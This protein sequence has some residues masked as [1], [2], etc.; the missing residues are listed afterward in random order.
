[1]SEKEYIVSLN[2]G[3]DYDRFNQEMIAST[4]AGD[5]PNRGVE[6]ANARPGSQR[7]T[8]YMLT[9]EE[10]I[11]LAKDSRVYAVEL[12]PDLRTDIQIG[13]LASQI[14]DFTKTTESRG[15]FVNWGLRRINEAINPYGSLSTTTGGYNYTLDGE[16]VDI[17]IQ[18]SGLQAD[19]PEFN[20]STGESRVQQI[21]WYTES[22][23]PGTM[24]AAHYTDYDGHGT[25]VAGI[26]AGATYGWAKG[27]RIYAVKVAG[28][29]GDTDPNNG[30]PISDCFDVITAW[31]NN[32]PVDPAT[33]VK[34]PTVVNMS[35]GYNGLYTIPTEIN[36]RGT[37]YTGAQID[38][39]A[40]LGALGLILLSTSTPGYYS[41][42]VRIPSVDIDVQEMIDAGI[43]VCIAAGNNYHKADITTG[44]DYN[45]YL[46][47]AYTGTIYYNRGS[48][49]FSEEAHIV[50][51]IDRAVHATLLE[52]KASSSTSGPAVNV[53][54]PGT[55]I[56]SCTSTTNKFTDGPYPDDENFRICNISGT[57]MA[58][59]QIAGLIAL[60]SQINPS[61][62]PAQAR[63]YIDT[64]AKVNQIYSTGSGN[65]YT[66]HRSIKDGPNRFA[67]NKYNS[68][69]Q[70]TLG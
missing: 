53:Y 11:A 30:I 46:V 60:Y 55:N 25:H 34:R 5:I 2:K 26:A 41:C 70:L 24:P 45:N 15:F 40:E 58:S 12:R 35:W 69:V 61:A 66:D 52:Q 17:V 57:S 8:H 1:M 21:D 64:T 18:D 50:G 67:F 6:V 38:T 31:H 62:T 32:K 14:D 29:E 28:L 33:G 47:N 51:N 44:A 43:H 65:D 49:P 59:P 22:G 4:G 13:R 54:A 20:D 10:A 37:S 7:N 68:A 56:M 39:S 23:L 36:Y 48:S 9:D 16:G 19:H 27:A 63:A 42:P 3:V